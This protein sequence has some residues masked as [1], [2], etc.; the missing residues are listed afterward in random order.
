VALTAAVIGLGYWGPNLVRNLAATPDFE[1]MALCDSD[2]GRLA[3]VG[4]TYPAA[5]RFSDVASLLRERP[6]ELVVIATP[7]ATHHALALAALR[8]GCHVLVEKPLAATSAEAEEV[9]R[10][11][12]A[13]DRRVLV[14]HTFLFTGAVAEVAR[15]HTSGA[16]GELLYVDSVRIALGL[17]QPDVDVIWDLAPH[18]L[19]ILQHVLGMSPSRI[20]AL[21]ASHNPRGLIDVAYLHLEYPDRLHAHLHLSWLSPVKIRRMVFAGRRQSLVFDDLEPA[22]K[23]KLYDHGVSFDVNDAEARREVLVSYRK[24]D[25]RAPAVSGTE[26]LAVEMQHVAQVLRG[27]AEPLAPGTAGLDVVRTLEAAEESLREEGRLI[28]LR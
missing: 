4:A 8:A 1:L 23:V 22:E 17:Y 14:D 3:R 20:R 9:L 12:D 27:E 11:A 16:L 24:G 25:M 10:V 19:S 26:A 18:D 5:R 13:A 28:T 15:Q 21:G 7:V 2:P 6:P